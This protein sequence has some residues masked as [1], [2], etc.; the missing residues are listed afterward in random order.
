ESLDPVKVVRHLKNNSSINFVFA[1]YVETSTLVKHPIDKLARQLQ[2]HNVYLVVDA[3]SAIAAERCKPGEWGV[4]AVVGGSQKGLMTPPGLSYLTVTPELLDR[5]KSVSGSTYFSL[6][7]A[8]KRQ[9]EDGQTPWTP[10]IPLIRSLNKS[11][12]RILDEGMEAVHDR[13]RCLAEACRGAVEAIGLELFT[14]SPSVIG[15][16]VLVPD[17]IDAG[18]VRDTIRSNTGVYIPGGR[19]EWSDQLIRIGHLGH[20]DPFDLLSTISALEIGFS[21]TPMEFSSG[22]GVRACQEVVLDWQADL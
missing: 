13:H 18:R 10:S 5:S 20:V 16:P 7:E 21:N 15:T 12:D 1:T 14:E 2:E 17:E 19:G 11:L 3:I 8:V 4:D 22:E 9:N 6:E